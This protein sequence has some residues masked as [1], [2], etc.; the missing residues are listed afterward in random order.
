MKIA[1]FSIIWKVALITQL[2]MLLTSTKS[3]ECVKMEIEAVAMLILLVTCRQGT[4]PALSEPKP[5]TPL[6]SIA[7]DIW[8][9]I[10]SYFKAREFFIM[11]KAG[12]LFNRPNPHKPH[13]SILPSILAN[14]EGKY[15]IQAYNL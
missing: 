14:I 13:H 12:K 10:L 8:V 7:V 2:Q 9:P 4:A 3:S 11:K 15:R 1:L 6:V 5:A